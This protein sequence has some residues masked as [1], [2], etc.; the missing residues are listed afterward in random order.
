MN[1]KLYKR[2]HTLAETMVEAVAKSNQ[3]TFDLCYDELKQLCLEHEGVERKDHPVQWETLADFTEDAELAQQYYQ[4]ALDFAEAIENQDF[5]A[6]INYASAVLSIE[7]GQP[8]L[9]LPKLQAA[10]VAAAQTGDSELQREVKQL[11]K[12]LK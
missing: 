2:V 4:K 3:K 10:D 5:I 7:Q 1:T 8:E 6:S 11:L 9:A 12:K